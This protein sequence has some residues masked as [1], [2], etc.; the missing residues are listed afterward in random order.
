MHVTIKNE[1]EREHHNQYRP[2]EQVDAP[3][4]NE[5][6]STEQWRAA[7][8]DRLPLIGNNSSTSRHLAQSSVGDNHQVFDN[9]SNQPLA[10]RSSIAQYEDEKYSRRRKK[11][12]KNTV[13]F[14][15]EADTA[16]NRISQQDVMFGKGKGKFRVDSIDTSSQNSSIYKGSGSY[17]AAS[18]GPVHETGPASS[19]IIRLNMSNEYG[20]SPPRAGDS[21]CMLPKIASVVGGLPTG[22]EPMGRPADPRYA[23]ANAKSIGGAA[24]M[25]GS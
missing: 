20:H 4:F 7:Q 24:S 12:N 14:R 9:Q 5:S 22:H 10:V 19:S 21:P 1:S 3:G 15:K 2:A 8:R 23:K 11:A 25:I 6:I 16:P 18:S 13:P 17:N